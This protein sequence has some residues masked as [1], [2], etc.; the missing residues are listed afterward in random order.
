M[1]LKHTYLRRVRYR[2]C[3][4][5][6]IAYH[7][8]YLDYFEEARTEALRDAGLPYKSL[9]DAGIIMPVVDAQIRYHASAYYDDLLAIETTFEE[10]KV[11]AP[12]HYAVRRVD[13]EKVLVS[14]TVVLCF[15][16]VARGRPVPAPQAVREA[17]DRALGRQSD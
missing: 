6:S 9:E 3:D 17:F 1:P 2:E 5:M 11:R 4:P 12:I 16:D 13:E 8:H 7:T 15:V 10:P 14:G